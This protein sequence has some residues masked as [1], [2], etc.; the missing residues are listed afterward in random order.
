MDEISQYFPAQNNLGCRGERNYSYK[1]VFIFCQAVI[2]S[3]GLSAAPGPRPTR[4]KRDDDGGMQTERWGGCGKT[5]TV[6]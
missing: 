6:R 1:A 4:T 5:N 2:N 3:V